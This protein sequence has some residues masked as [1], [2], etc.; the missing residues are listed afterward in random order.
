[1]SIDLG[2]FRTRVGL[3]CYFQNEM[4]GYSSFNQFELCCWLSMLLLLSGDV[5]ENPGP[6]TSSTSSLDTFVPAQGNLSLVDYNV[7]SI[8]NKKDILFGDLRNY[9]I[10]PFNET[11]LN[12]NTNSS[13]L[14]FPSFHTPFRR[15]RESDP[16]GGI[17]VYVKSDIFVLERRDLEVN[18]VECL[19]LQLKI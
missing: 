7:Q 2:T 13:D 16:H 19:W 17:I 3:F 18:D 14:P 12:T 8:L 11:W 6:S 4:K 9:D 15:D 10:L 5:H 1:M